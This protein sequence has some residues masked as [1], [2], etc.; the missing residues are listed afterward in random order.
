M[1]NNGFQTIQVFSKYE[2]GTSPALYQA[3]MTLSTSF[4]ANS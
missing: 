4:V 1:P 2:A 3:K